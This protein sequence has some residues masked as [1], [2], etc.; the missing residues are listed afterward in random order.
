MKPV[1]YT[2]VKELERRFE[3]QLGKS[4]ARREARGEQNH[5]ILTFEL[6][7][8]MQENE[9]LALYNAEYN[10]IGIQ[11]AEHTMHVIIQSWPIS[12]GFFSHF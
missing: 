7:G 1:P 2:V 11:R 5:V 3:E 12:P 10:L 9:S 4:S 8:D 6:S